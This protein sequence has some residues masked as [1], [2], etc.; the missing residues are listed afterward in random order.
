MIRYWMLAGLA[1][2]VVAPIALAR[3]PGLSRA[4]IRSMPITERP[5]R[6]GHFYGNAVRRN[7]SRSLEA[8]RVA[9][10][11]GT[12]TP[13]NVWQGYRAPAQPDAW[14]EN[15]TSDYVLGE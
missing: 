14:I 8:G 6:P 3:N 4:E 7:T 2:L 5:S 9:P 11:P 12:V 13:A 10:T 1:V 15:Q